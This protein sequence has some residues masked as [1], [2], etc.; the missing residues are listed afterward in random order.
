MDQ[1]LE[2]AII[3]TLMQADGRLIEDVHHPDQAGTDLAGETDTLRLTAGQGVG[4]ALQGQIVE[5]DIDEKFEARLDLMHDLGGDLALASRQAQLAELFPRLADRLTHDLGERAV[6]DIDVARFTT[7]ARAVAARARLDRQIAGEVLAHHVGFGLAV[8]ALHVGQH[9]LEGVL[10][11]HLAATVIHVAE[12]DV[13]AATAIEHGVT[14][15]IAERLPGRFQREAVML[16][17][18]LKL[19]E[20]V[21]AATVPALDDAFGQ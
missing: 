12:G 6:I 16:G 10:A 7:Q 20:V 5:A 2:Q 9:A 21:D 14:R 11:G 18:G 8:T 19:A 13:L 15:F 17:N 4:A 3:V 1:R